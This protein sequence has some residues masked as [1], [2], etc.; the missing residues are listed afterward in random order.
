MDYRFATLDEATAL[1]MTYTPSASTE[2][3]L[4]F[5]TWVWEA[6]KQI[7][8]TSHWVKVAELVP[9]NG[10]FKKP[11]DMASAISI[12]LYAGTEEVKYNYEPE[13]GGRVHVDR[14]QI[15]DNLVDNQVVGRVDLTDDAYYYHL[16]DNGSMVTKMMIRYYALPV[17][18]NG[19]LLIPEDN[20]FAVAMFCKWSW[21]MRKGDNQSEQLNARDTWYRE[22]GSIKGKNKMP[23]MHRAAEFFKN[24]A[25]LLNSYRPNTF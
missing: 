11:D 25:S 2:D 21:T 6:L 20:L 1:A 10:S 3:R 17:D 13:A 22:L 8:P 18:R 4:L 12:G 23:S 9:K 19:E 24:Y 16:G 15:H 14:F 7:G 5:R